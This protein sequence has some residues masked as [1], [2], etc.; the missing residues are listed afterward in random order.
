MGG[1]PLQHFSRQRHIEVAGYPSATGR[2]CFP[3]KVLCFGGEFFPSGKLF[4]KSLLPLKKFLAHSERTRRAGRSPESCPP[5]HLPEPAWCVSGPGP[6][7]P[8]TDPAVALRP[9]HLARS[10]SI[11]AGHGSPVTW[12]QAKLPEPPPGAPKRQQR[13]AGGVHE[14]SGSQA[15]PS[16]S[17]SGPTSAGRGRSPSP[18][19][20]SGREFAG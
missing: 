1:R 18:A 14:R 19:F 17:H 16:R 5:P 20:S 3:W 4:R 10:A 7:G 11:C 13:G 12:S 9:C 2:L 6:G 8:W 15:R